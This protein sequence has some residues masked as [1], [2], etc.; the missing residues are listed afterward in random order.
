[1]FWWRIL[2]ANISLIFGPFDLSP[3]QLRIEENFQT[4]SPTLR[5]FP[6]LFLCLQSFAG[7]LTLILIPLL[8]YSFELSLSSTKLPSR[9]RLHLFL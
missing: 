6:F 5:F 2:A 8:I 3:L 1:M 9:F 7:L 4:T